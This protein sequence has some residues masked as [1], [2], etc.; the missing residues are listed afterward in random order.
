MPRPTLHLDDD[1]AVHRAGGLNALLAALAS[2]CLDLCDSRD[3]AALRWCA[4]SRCTRPFIDRSHGER[5]RWFG[6]KVA[7]T[8][9]KRPPTD[10]GNATLH[11][12]SSP[13]Q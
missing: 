1:G 3:R 9:P 5:R 4:D 10:V 2:D 11:T 8:A 6:I 13:P 12:R 7:A